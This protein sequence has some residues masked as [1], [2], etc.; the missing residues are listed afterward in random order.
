[1]FRSCNLNG[2]KIAG[3]NLFSAAF[4]KCK[5]MG[6]DFREGITLTAATFKDCNL[7]YANFQGVSLERMV[8]E[9]SSFVEANL[10]FTNLERASFVGCDLA[11]ADIQEAKFFQ[12]DLRGANL[13]GWNLRQHDLRGVIITPAQFQALAAELGIQVMKL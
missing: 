9:G 4:E 3:S 10:S 1:M 7:D 2:V 6:V 13:A 8:F 5:L 12:T 11:H